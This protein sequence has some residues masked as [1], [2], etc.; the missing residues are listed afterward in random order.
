MY[1][2]RKAFTL[3]ELLVVIAIIAVLIA[4]LLPAVQAA[5]EAARR[6]QCTNNMKQLALACHNH[7]DSLGRLPYGVFEP[8]AVANKDI[9]IDAKNPFGPNWLIYILP[10]VEQTSLYNSCNVAG[11]PGPNAVIVQ[12]GK[13]TPTGVNLEWRNTTIRGTVISAFLCPSDKGNAQPYSDPAATTPRTT[14]RPTPTT[15]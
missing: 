4:L 2:R 8:Y 3:I 15:P 1:Q 11:Y 7:H 12:D 13:T 10:Y 14:A 9:S 5:R 6:M